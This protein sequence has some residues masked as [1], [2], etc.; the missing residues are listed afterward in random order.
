MAVEFEKLKFTRDWNSSSDFPT[1]E[2]SEQ[3][4][5]ADLQALHDE[6]KEFINEKLIPNIEILAVPGTGDMKT[7][8]YDPWN[9]REDV[10]QY[11]EDKVTEAVEEHLAEAHHVDAYSKDETL[12][13]ETREA[14][15]IAEDATPDGAFNVMHDV[16]KNAVTSELYAWKIVE[17]GHW[18]IG[19]RAPATTASGKYIYIA[20][21]YTI[22]ANGTF[23]LVDAT[24]INI[25]SINQTNGKYWIAHSS[26]QTYGH[27][28]IYYTPVD[29]PDGTVS[30]NTATKQF[31]V[32]SP[33]WKNDVVIGMVLSADINAY[34]HNEEQ[35]GQYYEFCGKLVEMLLMQ[36]ARIQQG[37]YGGTNACGASNPN[38]LTFEFVPKFVFISGTRLGYIYM[39]EP[40]VW[41]NVEWPIKKFSGNT[42]TVTSNTALVDGTTLTWYNTDAD[43]GNQLNAQNEAYTYI[44]IG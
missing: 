8:V 32:L 41:G 30:S 10:Y 7:E 36:G 14:L 40:Y 16:L 9:K 6:T 24:N 2:E 19:G 13:A 20:D 15:G 23:T 37:S 4:V 29:S 33:V 3:K 28:N 26:G 18:D 17:P 43:V 31:E 12:S 27:K 39:A 42:V 22:E 21:S 25:A 35:N 34:P 1:Y 11:A 44:A 5:R 38:T